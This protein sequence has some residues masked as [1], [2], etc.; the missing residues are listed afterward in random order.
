M[1]KRLSGQL[2]RYGLLI[3]RIIAESLN[4]RIGLLAP[5]GSRFLLARDSGHRVY[6]WN[7][8]GLL[9]SKQASVV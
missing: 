4:E 9:L 6:F 7:R 3:E 5:F 2:I 8:Q 1:M